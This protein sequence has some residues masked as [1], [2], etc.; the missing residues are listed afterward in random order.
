MSL[1]SEFFSTDLS[2]SEFKTAVSL[3]HLSDSKGQVTATTEELSILTGYSAESLRRAF[4]GLEAAGLLETTRTKR[5]FGKWSKN[6]YQLVLPSHNPVDL[7]PEPSHKA[8][9][10]TA[11]YVPSDTMTTMITGSQVS[12]TRNTS[13]FLVRAAGASGEEIVVSNWKD[14]DDGIAGVGLFEDELDGGQPKPKV[15]KRKSSTRNLRPESEWTTND[16]AAEFSQQLGKRFPYTPGLVNTAALRGALSNYRRQYGTSPEVEMQLMRMFF[17]DQHNLKN[18][19]SEAHRI[20][21]R[22]LNMFKT[23]LNKAYEILGLE[24]NHRVTNLPS[25]VSSETELSDK[26]VYASDGRKFDRSIVGRSALKRYEEKL[27]NARTAE[28]GTA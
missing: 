8:V 2:P 11:D 15:D 25:G 28:T 5:N 23:H 19:D 18:A 4:R 21:G 22:Y 9:G 20:H 14:D 12:N 6:Q 27:K 13:Y 16:I 1:P 24:P 17:A 10:S 7:E 26:Y 3:Y